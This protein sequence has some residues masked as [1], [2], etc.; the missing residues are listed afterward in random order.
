MTQRTLRAGLVGAGQWAV[1][2]H[3]PGL[4]ATPG[5]ELVAICD[6]DLAR[7]RSAAT[8]L[9]VAAVFGDAAAML[10]AVPLDLVCVVTPDDEHAGPVAAACA[11]GVHVLCEK[12]L[13]TTVAEARRLAVLAD[14][15]GIQTRVGF[16]MRFAPAMRRL[17]DLVAAGA[18]GEPRHVQAFQ[19]NGQFLD[20][21]TPFHWKMDE[22]RTGGGA[23][24]EYGIHTLDLLRWV[25][26]EFAAVAAM[27]ATQVTERPLPGGGVVAVQVDD[28]TSWLAEFASGATGVC[29]AGWATAGRGPGVELRVYGSRGAVRCQLTDDLPG[30]EGLWLAGPDG[31][32]A[33][34][35]LDPPGD[36]P[37]W[38]RFPTLLIADFAAGIWAGAVGGPTFD[39][40]VRAQEALAAVQQA[41]RE[42]RWVAV[43]RR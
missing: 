17:R 29:H 31:R 37:W 42:R 6:T 21:A 2:A 36:D 13:A 43:A 32:L 11:R 5:V 34:V 35:P 10:E 16:T 39:D 27:S 4:L 40:G 23:I 1:A 22:A 12:P 30:A 25:M 28:S 26:G 38:V 41:A 7:A 15:A 20:P 3:L 8:A 14:A 24:V 33:P 9:G 19:Q 18:I